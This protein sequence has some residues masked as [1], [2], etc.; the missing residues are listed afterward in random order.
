[1]KGGTLNEKENI[2]SNSLTGNIDA[3]YF[4]I[5]RYRNRTAAGEARIEIPK[6]KVGIREC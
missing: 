1:M 6:H 4:G 3:V 2:D 5:P